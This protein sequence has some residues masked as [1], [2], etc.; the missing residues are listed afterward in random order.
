LSCRSH[1][2]ARRGALTVYF[3][4]LVLRGDDETDAVAPQLRERVD[5]VLEQAQLFAAAHIERDGLVEASRL[6][7]PERY[8]FHYVS[9]H[10]KTIVGHRVSVDNV[11]LH[12]ALW[13]FSNLLDVRCVAF[14][15]PEEAPEELHATLIHLSRRSRV[16][17]AFSDSAIEE[18][19]DAFLS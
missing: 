3:A 2:T 7:P 4:E 19:V 8:K 17:D 11:H 5:N 1:S 16:I 13:K 9:R 6:D 18:A 15:A 14:V 10:G 12:D